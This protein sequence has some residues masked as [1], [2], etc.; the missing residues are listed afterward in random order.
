LD[1]TLDDNHVNKM[2]LNPYH[3][4]TPPLTILPIIRPEP[5]ELVSGP[6]NTSRLLKLLDS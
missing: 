4:P 5:Y 6:F 2:S 3:L 1:Y